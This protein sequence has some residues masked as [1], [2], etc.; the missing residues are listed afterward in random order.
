MKDKKAYVRLSVVL[1]ELDV[2][3]VV[4][5]SGVV[6]TEGGDTYANDRGDWG[7]IPRSEV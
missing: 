7:L 2:Q 3:D 4:C 1:Q 6:Q 5:T